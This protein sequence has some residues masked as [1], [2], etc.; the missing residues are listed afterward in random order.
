MDNSELIE[1]F[2]NRTYE[3][4]INKQILDDKNYIVPHQQ[5]INY[6]QQLIKI[7]Y[8]E[9]IN[10]LKKSKV[11]KV[12]KVSEITQISSFSSCEID[13]CKAL[14]RTNNPGCQYID[15]GRF[16]PNAVI[17]GTEGA[18]RKYGENHIKAAAQLG[19]TFEYYDYWY[20]S[21]LGYVYSNLT[22]EE[23]KHLLARTITRNNLYQQMLL[24]VIEHDIRLDSYMKILSNKTVKRRINNVWIFF[25]ICLEECQEQRIKKYNVIREIK[26][27]ENR[28]IIDFKSHLFPALNKTIQIYLAEI[29][30]NN[31][32]SEEEVKE[33]FRQYKKGDRKAYNSLVKGHL[34]LVFNIAYIYKKEGMFLDDLIQEGNIG[35]LKAI[36]HFDYNRGVPFSEYAKMWIFQ[37]ISYSLNDIPYVVKLPRTQLI[38]F[39]KIKKYINQFEQLYDYPPSVADVAIDENIDLEKV[40]YLRQ[41]PNDL[42][43]MTRFFEMDSFESTI[44]QTDEFQEKDFCKY[45]TGK[46]MQFLKKRDRIIV[47]AFF[48]I[49]KDTGKETLSYIGERMNITRERAR[50]ILVKSIEIMHDIFINKNKEINSSDE[51]FRVKV[52]SILLFSSSW[53][54]GRITNIIKSNNG[55][56][57]YI[58]KMEKGYIKECIEGSELYTILKSRTITN[59]RLSNPLQEAQDIL[60]NRIKKKEIIRKQIN[61]YN[62]LKVGD[63]IIYK[64]EQCSVEKIIQRSGMFRLI[65]KYQNG[66]LDDILYDDT[67]FAILPMIKLDN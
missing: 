65:I 35:L 30:K 18:Y 4:F 16:F 51:D 17:S 8:I 60:N 36:D 37:Y 44:Y 12:I 6:I 34:K 28:E 11:N 47:K 23:R 10:Y 63:N 62:N 39:K 58:L 45:Q 49:E 21:C 24:D 41:L 46:L 64:G 61:K 2:Y 13:L 14:L 32:Y 31:H 1:L 29:S 40:T 5:L 19:L 26:E 38:N 48:G 52:G 33:L 66:I 54:F 57:K 43:E 56:K 59:R 20:L 50:Q 3:K 67:T 27:S 7:P 42:M 53:D 25:N 15:I 55:Q 22:K 9:F